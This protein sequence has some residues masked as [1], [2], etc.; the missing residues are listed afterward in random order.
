MKIRTFSRHLR[1]GF[2]N[3]GR[4]GWMSFASIS[5]VAITLFILGV[6]LL[7]AL[8][9]NHYTQVVENQVEI[10]VFLKKETTQEQIEKLKNQLE[11]QPG[12]E[13]VTF[14]TKEEGLAK[15]RESFGEK[16]YWFEGLD[17][18]NPLSDELAIKPKNPQ[19]TSL[20]AD[21]ISQYP[22][23]ESVNY[24]KGTIEKLFS[25]TKVIRN[26]GLGFIIALA[27]TAMFLISNTIKLTIVA[28][29]REIQIMK[30]VGATN[31][32]IRWPFFIEGLLLGVLGA[33]VP[34][35]LLVMGYQYLIR[36]VQVDLNLYFLEL[37]PLDPLGWQLAGLLL[38]IG[39]FIGVW[40][41]V[42]SVRRFLRI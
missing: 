30:L 1:E 35:A 13:S 3:I 32:F 10:R 12:I 7:L 24:G 15:F 9:I 38:G 25:I 22:H 2:R 39:A 42:V 26:V 8:N 21:R 19:E 20:V 4:N 11:Q 33:V 34:I 29:R 23:I 16:A 5:S 6:F 14:I 37:L 41:S 28:R 40:G 31:A 36:F 27:F 17:E 18:E